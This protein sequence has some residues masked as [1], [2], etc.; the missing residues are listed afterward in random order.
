MWL[1][2]DQ[3]ETNLVWVSLSSSPPPS[4]PRPGAVAKMKRTGIN[5]FC[6]IQNLSSPLQMKANE[7]KNLFAQRIMSCDVHSSNK[8]QQ[9]HNISYNMCGNRDFSCIG[10]SYLCEWMVFRLASRQKHVWVCV[11]ARLIG[12]HGEFKYS[13]HDLSDEMER[14]MNGI[15]N[16]RHF[17][18][19]YSRCSMYG[20]HIRIKVPK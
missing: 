14:G 11:C 4:S 18:G 17:Y 10:C 19:L 9:Q 13:A 12:R 6:Q 1:N 16:R 3:L 5:R 20:S 2:A 15:G 8:K 7:I